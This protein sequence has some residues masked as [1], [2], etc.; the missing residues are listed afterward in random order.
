MTIRRGNGDRRWRMDVQGMS[1]VAGWWTYWHIRVRVCM[2]GEETRI[3]TLSFAYVCSVFVFV[4]VQENCARAKTGGSRAQWTFA[5]AVAFPPPKSPCVFSGLD[6]LFDRMRIFVYPLVLL[7]VWLYGRRVCCVASVW[8][9]LLGFAG[10]CASL[11]VED[12][13]AF[14]L[15]LKKKT[16]GCVWGGGG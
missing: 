16:V 6:R 2:M 12:V 7:I 3:F 11:S 1:F 14:V 5:V 8:L 9:V 10:L 13:C 15:S 4:F